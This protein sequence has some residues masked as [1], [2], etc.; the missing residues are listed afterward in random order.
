M[1]A[2]A[3]E[4]WP[5][6][7]ANAWYDKQP[8]LVG[9]NFGPSTAI[10]QLEMWQADSFD[11]A[12]IDRE[13][14][15]A[16][17]LG[18]NSMRVFLHH[19]LW[20]QDPEGFLKRLD[21]YLEVSD[22]HGVGT[23]FVLF[24]SVWDPEPKLGKQREPQK[25][26]HNSGWVQSPGKHDLLNKDRHK[27][28]E[29]YVK[30]VVG[31]FKDDKRVQIWDV[32]NEPDNMNGN[33]YGEKHLKT[34]PSKEQK[35]AAVLDLLP[36]V[37]TWCREAGATQPL[38]SG[39]WLGGHKADPAKL[40]PIEKVQLA[41]SDVISF[42]CYDNLKGNETWV[43]RLREHGRPLL[44]TEYMARPQGSEFDPILAWYKKEKI[45]AYNW[46]FVA[47]K[48]NTIYPWDSWQKPYATEPPVWFHDIFRADGTPYREAEVKYIRSVTG[49][50]QK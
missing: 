17:G 41:E 25:G 45:A 3:A 27:L 24:D 4:R 15:W 11:L 22:K 16:K 2:C 14:S 48:T 37:F 8:W 6:D 36:K 10:N 13:L 42:H 32:W 46:G 12:T 47:G 44:S 49:A 38:T 35:Q 5:A 18:F 29:A 39:L 43:K 50:G 28:L 7:K 21:Q 34:E 40:I 20:E 26:L 19:L 23:M 33:S 1:T 31:R 30:G 9:A